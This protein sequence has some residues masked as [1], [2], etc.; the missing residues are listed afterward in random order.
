MDHCISET[1]GQWGVNQSLANIFSAINCDIYNNVSDGINMASATVGLVSNCNFVKNGGWG[2]K[3]S[4]YNSRPLQV[5][6]CGFGSGTMANTN[7]TITAPSV[8]LV[9]SNT[10]TYASGVTPWVDPANGAFRINLAA[11]KNTGR[12]AF[13]QT[14]A[15]YAGAIGYPDIGAAQHLEAPGGVSR[16]RKG[17]Q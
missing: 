10:V 8:N 6:N 3:A 4:A 5:E 15:S 11:A 16:T 14:Q 12:G 13:T 7:G 2:I 17:T 1:N 9:Q